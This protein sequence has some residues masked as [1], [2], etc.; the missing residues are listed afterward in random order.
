[1]LLLLNRSFQG[2]ST[3]YNEQLAKNR[4]HSWKVRLPNLKVFSWNRTK[5]ELSKVAE[6]YRR[7]YGGEAQTCPP[8]YKRLD[9]LDQYLR[10]L[11]TYYL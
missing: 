2:F 3:F 4:Q 6:F 9:F 1:M 5:M 11:W 8:P 7:L 10:S